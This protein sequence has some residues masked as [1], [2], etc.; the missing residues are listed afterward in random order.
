MKKQCKNCGSYDIEAKRMPLIKGAVALLL[1]V[2]TT[3]LVLMLL[4][5]G[6]FLLPVFL[7]I[8]PITSI[9]AV[10]MLI[11]SVFVRGY[12]CKSCKADY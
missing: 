1:A 7:F 3:M 2:P 6:I 4:I 9:L 10:L 8:L 12:A 5:I 11:L